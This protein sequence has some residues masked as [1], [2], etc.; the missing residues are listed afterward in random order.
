MEVCLYV[1]K[2]LSLGTFRITYIM[3]NV[4]VEN[5]NEN[6]ELPALRKHGGMEVEYSIMYI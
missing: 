6:T 3:N 1:R 4:I 2:Q 5:E